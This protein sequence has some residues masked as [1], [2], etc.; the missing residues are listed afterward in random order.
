MKLLMLG[1]AIGCQIFAFASLAVCQEKDAP[2]RLHIT[3]P[4][5]QASPGRVELTA[6]SIERDLSSKESESIIL[7]KGNVEV[8]MITCGRSKSHDNSLVCDEGSIILHADTV[9][10]N[11]K[12]GEI[13]AHGN[14]HLT[15]YQVLPQAQVSN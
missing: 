14:V 4:F 8:R 11:E 5:P 15:P 3:R 12:T 1:V 9:D 10:Y 6:S 2:E 7:L 13:S